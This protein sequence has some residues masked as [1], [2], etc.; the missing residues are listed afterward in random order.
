IE[1]AELHEKLMDFDML[2]HREEPAMS[3]TLVVTANTASRSHGQQQQPRYNGHRTS[4]A[5]AETNESKVVCQYCGKPGHIA[6]NC[7]KIKGYP[8]KNGG[9]PQANAATRQTATHHPN[10]I[11]DTGASH[12]IAQD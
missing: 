7:F 1:F 10:W 11:I 12:H 9:R 2:L 4:H 6:R 3:D 8:R 5:S